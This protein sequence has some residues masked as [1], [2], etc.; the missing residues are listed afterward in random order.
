MILETE[1]LWLRPRTMDD[2]DDC[3]AMDCQPGVT[4]FVKGPWADAEEHRGFISDRIR[5]GYGKGLGYWT[6]F[7]KTA[8][9][10]FIGW[11][12]LIPEDAKGPEIEIGWRLK[13]EFWGRGY[14][15]EAAKTLL[16]HGFDNVK[17]PG[18]VA[19]IDHRNAGSIA[20]ARKIG[21]VRSNEVAN[22]V[23]YAMTAD[24]FAASIV[25]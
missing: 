23:L 2:L 19:C 5:M 20:V 4:D 1:R 16:C 24:E 18:M 3:F 6:L 8:P 17:L 15:T 10:R 7:A 22:D 9:D 12:L 13:P 14:A 21:M 11:V 25:T